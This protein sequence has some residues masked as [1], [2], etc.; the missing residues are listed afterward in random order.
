LFLNILGH[1]TQLQ[2]DAQY[3]ATSSTG[4]PT[5]WGGRVV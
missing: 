4:G 1:P 2:A 5:G 3:Y